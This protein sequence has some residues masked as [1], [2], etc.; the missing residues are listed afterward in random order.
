[1][2]AATFSI[3]FTGAVY[4]G[5]DMC[6]ALGTATGVLTGF[7]LTGAGAP[8]AGPSAGLVGLIY[9]LSC[10]AGAGGSGGGGGKF[11]EYGTLYV[12]A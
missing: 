1:M 12:A 7:L 3:H 5:V 10:A 8:F 4:S 9:A 11:D 6:S 2:R